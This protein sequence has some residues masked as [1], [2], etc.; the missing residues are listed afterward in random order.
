MKPVRIAHTADIHFD[1]ENRTAAL[2]SLSVLAETA[3][4]DA[5]DLIVIAGDLF[6]RGV[7]NTASSGLPDLIEAMIRLLSV[8]P[9]AAVRGTPTHDLPGSY[10]IFT[11]LRARHR[12]MILERGRAYVLIRG[13]E[14]LRLDAV[15]GTES[16]NEL[17]DAV[18]LVLG[19]GE[20]SREL[21]MPG[22]GVRTREEALAAAAAEIRNIFLEAAA[23][24]QSYRFLPALFVYHGAVEGVKLP[25]GDGGIDLETAAG[26]KDLQRIG[27]EYLALGHIHLAQKLGTL[28]AYYPGSAFPCSWGELDRKGFNLVTIKRAANDS[29]QYR[30]ERGS[31]IPAFSVSVKR[32][33]YPHSPRKK[34]TVQAGER[35]GG[36][37]GYQTWLEILG[38][39]DDLARTDLDAERK[40]L[41]AEGALSGS[42]VTFSVRP[43]GT[44]RAAAIRDARTLRQKLSVWSGTAGVP[45]DRRI[46]EKADTLEHQA[47]ADGRP[48]N[49]AEIRIRRLALRGA[50]GL[51]KGG[52]RDEIEIDLDRFGPGL[53]GLVGPNGAGKTTLIENM[54]PYTS[55]LTRDGAL[56]S[57]FRLKDSFRD[58]YFRDELTG[59]EYRAL[60]RIDPTLSQPKAEFTLFRA[61]ADGWTPLTNGR[62]R[63][64]EERIEE[65]FGSLPLFLKSAFI[66][67]RPTSKSPDFTDATAQ[68]RKALFR[69]LAGLGYLQA[70][71]DA[72]REKAKACLDAAAAESVK[73]AM[74]EELVSGLPELERR[75]R[76]LD[77]ESSRL[78][79]L[80][81]QAD[82]EFSAASGELGSVRELVWEQRKIAERLSELGFELSETEKER[83]L[84]ETERETNR[85]ELSR[86]SEYER[87]TAMAESLRAERERLKEKAAELSGRKTALYVEHAGASASLE[88]ELRRLE[89]AAHELQQQ[90]VR[91]ERELASVRAGLESLEKTILEKAVPTGSVCPAC[92]RPLPER[93]KEELERV[94]ERERIS[95]EEKHASAKQS[96]ERLASELEGLRNES[97]AIESRRAEIAAW[98]DQLSRE[99]EAALAALDTESLTGRLEAIET[100]LERIETENPEERLARAREAGIRIGE[101]E[102]RL[103]LLRERKMALADRKKELSKRVDPSLED[104]LTALER[105]CGEISSERT[106]LLSERASRTAEAASVRNRIEE[107][108]SRSRELDRVRAR[109]AA[110]REDAADWSLLATACG[111]D[112]IQALE[113]DAL[114]PSI[115]EVANRLLDEA[116]GSRFRL[117]FRTTRQ[118]GRGANLRQ[119]EDFEIY[120]L[121]SELGGEQVLSTLSGGESVWVKKAIYDAFGIV[122]ARNTGL[123]F[124]TA[125]QDEADGALDA[126]AKTR[127]FAMLSAAHR[128]SGRYHTILITHSTE[129][130]EMLAQKIS[131][132]FGGLRA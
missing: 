107:T 9:V 67:Q 69:E 56:Q 61:E 21:F 71:T 36:F 121:D 18:L 88:T 33:A 77:R 30:P 43:D 94:R 75:L 81:D 65:L 78:S 41:L 26:R 44:V 129:L 22:D 6:N 1:R 42:R 48:V 63:E 25:A 46:L 23:L 31:D 35:P 108:A 19:A 3:E 17:E 12:F 51:W 10:E 131:L 116:Y 4:R 120:V 55:M 49:G 132:G 102:A 13:P 53:I 80:L 128:E 87:Q 82:A 72:A 73:F 47:A 45:L 37:E 89:A 38:S 85:E 39:K 114:A 101:Q 84:L 64:Y 96:E 117:E 106:R 40:R 8:A 27:A 58:L 103:S 86:K 57:H 76:E 112:G 29:R 24:R 90:I 92:G 109:L 7:Q 98:K 52:R 111:P 32:T 115:A 34:I 91:F 5:V 14:G 50:V 104:R 130:Q 11:S 74:L 60:A 79:L 83:S 100:E 16:G 66:T 127:Y 15:T 99:L 54:H 59:T 123:R 113:L 105:R 125:F 62:T 97:G 70:Y 95:L 118:A 110:L 122:R 119:I 28:P 68:E 124:L 126:E 2:L 93:R 20:P